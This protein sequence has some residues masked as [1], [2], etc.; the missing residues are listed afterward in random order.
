MQILRDFSLTSTYKLLCMAELAVF[1][2]DSVVRGNWELYAHI[3][4]ALLVNSIKL[5]LISYLLF[6]FNWHISLLHPILK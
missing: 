4:Y 2:L 5:C 3:Y 1:A 6:I